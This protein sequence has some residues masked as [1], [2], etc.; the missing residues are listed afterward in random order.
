M[1]SY[2]EDAVDYNEDDGTG[3]LYD[4]G[5]TGDSNE[6]AGHEDEVEPEKFKMRVLEMEE[7]LEKLTKMQAQVEK[8]ISSTSDKMDESSM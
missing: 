8:Q 1:S 7:E 5:V 6:G 4:E 3:E 2:E